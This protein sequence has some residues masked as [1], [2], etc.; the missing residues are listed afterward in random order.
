MVVV[1]GFQI[2]E[3]FRQRNFTLYCFFLVKNLR[4]SLGVIFYFKII[5]VTMKFKFEDNGSYCTYQR[6][7]RIN[8]ANGSFCIVLTH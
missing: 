2:N 5:T 1:T 3:V 6:F 7:Q 8:E 4:H